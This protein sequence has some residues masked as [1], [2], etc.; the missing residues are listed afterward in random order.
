LTVPDPVAPAPH[1]IQEF[2]H[3]YEEDGLL[4]GFRCPRCGHITATWGLACSQCGAPGL[5]EARLSGR[6][7]IVAFTVLNVPGDEFVNDAPYAYIV[8]ELDGGG[9]VTG[10]MPSVRSEADLALGER[11]QFSPSYKPG[12]QFVRESAIPKEGG[13][14]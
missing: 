13:D 14:A 7:R 12:V 10:W 11:V 4:R 5:E 2:V 1:S 8:V 9:R 6:G 3:G